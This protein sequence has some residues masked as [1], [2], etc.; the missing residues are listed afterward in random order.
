MTR[1]DPELDPSLQRFIERATAQIPVPARATAPTRRSGLI[2]LLGGVALFALV[3]IAAVVAGRV[4]TD[5]RKGVAAVPV[6][7]AIQAVP[8]SQTSGTGRAS[9]DAQGDL[10]LEVSVKGP[11]TEITKSGPFP[12]NLIW[13]LLEGT[14][15]QWTVNEPDHKVIARW[16]IDPQTP[17]SLDFRY[18]VSRGDLDAMSRP[19]A[20]AAFQNG[21]GG[22]LYACGDLPPL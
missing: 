1:Q 8:P 13:H 6:D 17:S 7:F 19:H 4:L 20:V 9:Y 12:A 21:G 2:S 15:A 18:V 11:V 5:T 16:T 3:V 10:V 14:C 22:P